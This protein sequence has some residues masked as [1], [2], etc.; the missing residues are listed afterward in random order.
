MQVSRG[1]ASAAALR[2]GAGFY[3]GSASIQCGDRVLLLV[4][5]TSDVWRSARASI[6]ELMLVIANPPAAKNTTIRGP[7]GSTNL[8]AQTSTSGS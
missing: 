4:R 8:N 7:V 2:V 1:G 3:V 5:Q 6:P